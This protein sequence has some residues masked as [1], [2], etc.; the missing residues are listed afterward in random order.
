MVFF[1]GALLVWRRKR[2]KRRGEDIKDND[3]GSRPVS[4]ILCKPELPVDRI[5]PQE[6]PL[7]QDTT[8]GLA[9]YELS[10]Q[11]T[12]SELPTKVLPASV[13]EMP[14]VATPRRRNFELP[15]LPSSPRP[16]RNKSIQATNVF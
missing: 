13:H 10:E 11:Q 16:A 3:K 15:G 9:P 4:P 2:S 6:M 7:T 5:P 8:Y 1:F 14:I 12:H